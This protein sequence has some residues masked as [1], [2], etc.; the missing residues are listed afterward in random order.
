MAIIVAVF[1]ILF[2]AVFVIVIVFTFFV[3][4]IFIVLFIVVF[5]VFSVVVYVVFIA[6]KSESDVFEH[7]FVFTDGSFSVV[8][9]I[10]NLKRTILSFVE[11]TNPRISIT[12]Y[13]NLFDIGV[14]S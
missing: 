2:V 5:V 6:V 8:R 14:Y 9:T 1:V 12:R 7:T 13:F 10:F 3:L 11:H 4:V